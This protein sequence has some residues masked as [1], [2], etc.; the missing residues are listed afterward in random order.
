MKP[1]RRASG[2]FLVRSRPIHEPARGAVAR[3]D[4]PEEVDDPEETDER[5]QVEGIDDITEIDD[6]DD[7]IARVLTG[8]RHDDRVE[9]SACLTAWWLQSVRAA[10][11]RPSAAVMPTAAELI[12]PLSMLRLSPMNETL[13]APAALMLEL[14]ALGTT[15]VAPRPGPIA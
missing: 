8:L 13:S 15:A 14:A 6:I 9:L 5:D 10:A 11:R 3:F 4:G 12:A 1:A 7:A 2:A